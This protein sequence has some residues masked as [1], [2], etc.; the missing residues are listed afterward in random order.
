MQQMLI[1][2]TPQMLCHEDA[3]AARLRPRSREPIERDLSNLDTVL[4]TLLYPVFPALCD[5]CLI[6]EGRGCK[7]LAFYQLQ[8]RQRAF[9]DDPQYSQE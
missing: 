3:A 4:N 5:G 9:R 8:F 2:L 7:A 1:R 6:G